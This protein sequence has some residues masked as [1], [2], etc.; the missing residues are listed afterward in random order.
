MSEP[1][2]QIIWDAGEEPTLVDRGK[3]D[4]KQTRRAVRP[5]LSSH[6]R[7]LI[8]VTAV[9]ILLFGLGSFV[10]Q[11]WR[12]AEALRETL[13]EIRSRR[14]GMVAVRADVLPRQQE[15][16]DRGEVE[17][18]AL[19]NKLAADEREAFERHAAALVASN[20]FAD[21]LRQYETLAE[22]F[23]DDRTFRDLVTVLR[24]KLGCDP[25]A[26]FPSGACP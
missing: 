20:D 8:E 7:E 21:A 11:Q 1:P 23:P 24:V 13:A 22:L 26:R 5:L 16:S 10:H 6:R 4:A 19:V 2:T 17:R 3:Q 18:R 15:R 25:S 12:I 14:E 9:L